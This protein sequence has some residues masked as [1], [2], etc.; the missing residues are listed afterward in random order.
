LLQRGQKYKQWHTP[1]S[2][3]FALATH[4]QERETRYLFGFV[5]ITARFSFNDWKTKES[6]QK[7]GMPQSLNMVPFQLSPGQLF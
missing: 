6:A 1:G 4:S 5:I 7:W 2:S 3:F